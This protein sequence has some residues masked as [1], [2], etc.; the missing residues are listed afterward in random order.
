MEIVIPA[1]GL[2]SRFPN[3]RPKY[4]LTEYSGVKMI[5]RAIESFVGQHSITIGVLER[6]HREFPIDQ[7]LAKKYGDGVRVVVLKELTQGPA[8]TVRKII[9]LAGLDPAQELLV[10]DCDS[11]FDHEITPG[12]YI[13]TSGIAEHEV[14]KRLGSKSFVVA[15]NQGIVTDIIEKQVVSDKFCVGGYKFDSVELFCRAFDAVSNQN[16]A[17]IFVSHVIQKCLEWNEVFTVKAVSD[18][19]DVGTAEDWFE[20]NDK[21]VI[22]CD[23]DGT[24]VRAQ[25]PD[26]LGTTPVPLINAV[27]RLRQLEDDG[28]QL[29]FTTAR[30]NEFY[31]QTVKML[32]DL[33]FKKFN[34]ITGLLN[35]ARILVNDY[36]DANPYPRAT[37]INVRRDQDNLTDYL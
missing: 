5:D 36:N 28:H 25:S 14:L 15:N 8:D 29:I 21:S 32:Q 24:I 37:A 7:Y 3:M 20:H 2:S 9:E 17:E 27:C 16:V 10:K 30:Y 33:G 6:H 26:E 1:A 35:G 18:Y 11:F 23:I 4:T 34:L 19:V 31:D 13:C 22:F 12:N